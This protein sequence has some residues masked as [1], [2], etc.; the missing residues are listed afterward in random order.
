MFRGNTVGERHLRID[1][2]G[3]VEPFA[4]DAGTTIP[5]S[6]LPTLQDATGAVQPV[7]IVANG[8]PPI[9]EVKKFGGG[10]GIT[11]STTAT[12]VVVSHS[13]GPI[14][15]EAFIYYQYSPDSAADRPGDLNGTASPGTGVVYTVA[16]VGTWGGSGA[17]FPLGTSASW[18]HFNPPNDFWHVTD[19]SG[20]I[21]VVGNEAVVGPGAGGSFRISISAS[22]TSS[23]NNTRIVFTI[24]KNTTQKTGLYALIKIA[25][26]NDMESLSLTGMVNA[27][28]GDTLRLA[29]DS[30]KNTNLMF[31]YL[32]GQIVRV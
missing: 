21:T 11:V 30:D 14:L 16:N 7:S 8:A 26:A 17:N 24:L 20:N 10:T 31:E 3:V 23:Q 18:T 19:G 5:P 32:S 27:A 9:Y 29:F 13:S 4:V 22:C 28:A 25:S 12:D 6:L 1:Q 2:Y 15:T